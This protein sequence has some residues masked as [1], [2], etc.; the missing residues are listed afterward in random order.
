MSSVI[1]CSWKERVNTRVFRSGVSLHSH[2]NQ[3]KE[4]L[5]FIAAMG[6]KIPWLERFVRSREEKCAGQYGLK[7]DFDRAYWTPPLTPM[8]ALDLERGQIENGLQLSG[9][10]S[11]SDH[12]DINAPLLLRA[13]NAAEDTHNFRIPV[14]G[15]HAFHRNN[16]VIAEQWAAAIAFE[17]WAVGCH[18]RRR[19]ALTL[20]GSCVIHAIPL[21]P[22]IL[23]ISGVAKRPHRT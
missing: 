15:I 4:T 20:P 22:L 21:H 11:I 5:N 7:L 23:E 13:T 1:T 10:V 12:D 2:T 9:I 17:P 18:D 14:Q 16:V 8:Q 3:S 6:N 19:M